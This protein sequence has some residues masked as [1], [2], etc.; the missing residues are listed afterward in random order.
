MASVKFSRESTN[1][2]C[3]VTRNGRRGSG[4][5]TTNTGSTG[6]AQLAASRGPSRWTP[7]TIS[8]A[9]SRTTTLR[10]VRPSMNAACRVDRLSSK[11]ISMSRD[12]NASRSSACRPSVDADQRRLLDLARFFPRRRSLCE[13]VA[14]F[15]ACAGENQKARSESRVSSDRA[16][17]RDADAK[18][19]GVRHAAFRYRRPIRRS[20]LSARL[21]RE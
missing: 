8:Q 10:R 17:S 5:D 2:S 18:V 20:R 16:N 19:C 3:G 6:L 1:C 11:R 14:G 15:V 13:H 21:P 9:L 12:R 4:S 7:L